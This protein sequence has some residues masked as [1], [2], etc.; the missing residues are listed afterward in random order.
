MEKKDLALSA[1]EQIFSRSLKKE[2]GDQF[3]QLYDK[4]ADAYYQTWLTDALM[5][6]FK[7]WNRQPC[8]PRVRNLWATIP[9][10]LTSGKYELRISHNSPIWEKQWQVTTKKFI[11]SEL[12]SFGNPGAAEFV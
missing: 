10:G 1:D 3:Y 7:V 8:S 2:L 4:K 9:G 6:D 12:G 5:E 11:L